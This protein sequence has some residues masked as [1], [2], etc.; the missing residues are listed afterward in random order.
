MNAL[1][2]LVQAHGGALSVPV[3]THEVAPP[4][5]P[6]PPRRAGEPASSASSS[7]IASAIPP[8]FT[9]PPAPPR[10]LVVDD[11]DIARR[12]LITRLQPW[13]LRS[14][15]ATTSA[16]VLELLAR[17]SYELIFLDIELGPASELD[18]LALCRTIKRS[19]LA[20]EATVVL[21]SAH[22]SEVDRARG[23]LAG[24]DVY[25]GK[26]IKDA[27]LA[28]LLRRHRL[29]LPE[30]WSANSSAA[31]SGAAARTLPA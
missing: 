7:A 29:V 16:E 1:R 4:A 25:L 19:A 11:S 30:G 12:Y 13:G 20:I 15:I 21:V 31:T 8:R 23:A 18:G 17:C 26:P 22:H 9:G 5:A 6:P 10:A 2:R 24:C 28:V 3:L 14:D 27:E